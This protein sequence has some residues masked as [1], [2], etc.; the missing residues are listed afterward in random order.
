MPN[1]ED[2]LPSLIQK[3]L[4]AEIRQHPPLFP[5]ETELSDYETTE[6]ESGNPKLIQIPTPSPELNRD[7]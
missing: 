1:V 7:R 5:W 4:D 3:Q 6:P 2:R